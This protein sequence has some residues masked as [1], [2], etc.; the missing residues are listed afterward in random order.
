MNR[1]SRLLVSSVMGLLPLVGLSEPERAT[2]GGPNPDL[3]VMTF[4]IRVATEKDGENSWTHRQALVYD[5]LRR[6]QPL[7]IGMQ[8]VAAIQRQDL[9]AALPDYDVYGVGVR[10]DG[11]GLQSPIFYRKDALRVLEAG[12]FWLSESPE[13]PRTVSRYA[14]EPRIC[15]WVR[16]E[17]MVDGLRFYHFNTHLDNASA[18]AR[19]EGADLILQRIAGRSH[20]EPVILTGDFN[21]PEDSVPVRAVKE[22]PLGFVDTFRV[23]YPDAT[24][25][26]TYNG[27]TGNTHGSKIDYVF[28]P[29]GIRVFEAAIHHDNVN[30]RYL[31]DHFP[32]SAT[33]ALASSGAGDMQPPAPPAN[34]RVR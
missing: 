31:S 12:T 30:G 17:R 34:L 29:S 22:S 23:L 7:V 33:I 21:A 28:A 9:L 32:A 24:D 19:R 13:V 10:A 4:N 14:D 26:G 2:A 16:F 11:G 20:L 5:F 18:D 15:S 6:E 27:W 25:V 1:F 3:R 8:E